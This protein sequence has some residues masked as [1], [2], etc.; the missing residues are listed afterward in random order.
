VHRE[1]REEVGI[2]IA[3]ARYVASEPWP[4]PNSLMIGFVADYAGGTIRPD[5][6]EIESAGWFD[7][8]NLPHFPPKISITHALIQRWISGNLPEL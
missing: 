2:E 3:H 6:I 5:G 7:R 4:F 8:D 1:V